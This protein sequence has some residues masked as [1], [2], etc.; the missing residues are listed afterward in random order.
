MEHFN[1]SDTGFNDML[2]IGNIQDASTGFE[3]IVAE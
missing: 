2:C 3:K 1:P